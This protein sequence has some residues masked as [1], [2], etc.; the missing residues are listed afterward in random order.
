MGAVLA[1]KSSGTNAAASSSAEEEVN[2]N[3][4]LYRDEEKN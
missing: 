3:L 2:A 1:P 4:K